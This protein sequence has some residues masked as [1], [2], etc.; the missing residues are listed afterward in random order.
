[1]KMKQLYDS[2]Q[3]RWKEFRDMEAQR[4][5]D[6][7]TRQELDR[8]AGVLADSRARREHVVRKFT[9]TATVHRS[10]HAAATIQRAFRAMKTRHAW[11][12]RQRTRAERVKAEREGRAAQV[13]QR[14]WRGY[15]AYREYRAL[16]YRSVATCPVV[17]TS[18]KSP[19]RHENVQTKVHS[20]ERATSVTG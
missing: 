5:T 11:Q 2:R 18:C 6:K 15:R 10:H 7:A 13:I 9:Q 8:L 14:A 12:Q 20:Y 19:L 3:D 16:N 4:R 17:D 1:M